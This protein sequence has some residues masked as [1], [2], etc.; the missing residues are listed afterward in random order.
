M[1]EE[2]LKPFEMMVSAEWLH[3]VDSWRAKEPDIPSFAEAVQRL[4]A[5]GLKAASETL[6]HHEQIDVWNADAARLDEQEKDR[7]L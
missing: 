6:D 2:T 1:T 3:Q 5:V 7:K 4:V